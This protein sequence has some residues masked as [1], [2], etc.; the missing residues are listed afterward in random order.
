MELLLL[1]S[2]DAAAVRMELVAAAVVR[3]DH[4]GT[5][6]RRSTPPQ[7]DRSWL[8][9]PSFDLLTQALAPQQ[10]QLPQCEWNRLLPSRSTPPQCEWSWLLPAGC[11]RRSTC[12]HRHSFRKKQAATR[13]KQQATSQLEPG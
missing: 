8:L 2:F 9:L 13:S 4:T 7:C 6:C 11:C 3:P 12:S 1:R 10:R 5:C